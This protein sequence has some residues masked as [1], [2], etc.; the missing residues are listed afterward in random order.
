[1]LIYV[2]ICLFFVFMF[3]DNKNYLFIFMNMIIRVIKLEKGFGKLNFKV[4]DKY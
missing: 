1:M 4:Y 3:S 2:Y